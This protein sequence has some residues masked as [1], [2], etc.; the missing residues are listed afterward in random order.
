M[1]PKI[2]EPL[3]I[4]TWVRGQGI[5]GRKYFTSKIPEMGENK[6]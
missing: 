4:G 1:C 3:S 5:L 6:S 2:W